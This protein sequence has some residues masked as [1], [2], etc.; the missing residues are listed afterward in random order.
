VPQSQ[1]HQRRS[2]G[3]SRQRPQSQY[4][5]SPLY[6]QSNG[7]VQQKEPYMGG[8][9]ENLEE[10]TRKHENLIQLVISQ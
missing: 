3:D 8:S 10:L 2:P 4:Q 9:D 1:Q 7:L 6:N 5:P